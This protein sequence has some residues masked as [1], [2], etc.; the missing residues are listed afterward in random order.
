VLCKIE[1]AGVTL[2][3]QK[4]VLSK[5]HVTFLG[6]VVDASGI[7][8]DPAK[9]NAIAEMKTPTN[10]SEVRRILGMA[11]QKGEFILSS[12]GRIVKTPEGSAQ[13]KK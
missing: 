5:D 7:R 11:N 3:K 13:R 12:A 4:C 10:V 1:H 8:P 9:A 6:H 2:N